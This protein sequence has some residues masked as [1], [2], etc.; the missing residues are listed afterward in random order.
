MNRSL[1]NKVKYNPFFFKCYNVIGSAAINIFKPFISHKKR[2]IIFVSFGGRKYDDSP[3]AIYL[4]M[5]ADTRFDDYELIWAFGNTDEFIIPRGKKIKIDTPAYYKALLASRVW[6]TNSSITRGL[7][8]SGKKVFFL[9]TWH[10]TPIKKM[11]FD[12]AAGNTSFHK[13]IKE[14]SITDMM[15]AQGDYEADI[16]S[17]V[18][19]IPREKF[20]VIGLPRNDALVYDNNHSK[21]TEIKTKLGIPLNKKVI[22]YA[23]TFREYSKDTGNNCILESPLDLITLQKD[24]G[25]DYIFLLR[26]HYEV[27]KIFGVTDNDFVRNVSAYPDLNELMLVSDILVSDYSSIFFDYSILGRPMLPYCYDYDEYASKR[28]LYFDIRE[29][30]K[31]NAV[32]QAELTSELLTLDFEYRSQIA[33]QFRS[34]YISSFGNAAKKAADIIYQSII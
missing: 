1:I 23:P 34:E 22:L 3:K 11:G 16:F 2:Q 31:F 17:R 18:F 4:A 19:A 24:L 33:K 29:K 15:L 25:R 14:D 7:S 30:L 21:I 5:I 9:N 28:G 26:A 10:G 13:A 20:A 27:V 32:S 12:I 8:F 6:V